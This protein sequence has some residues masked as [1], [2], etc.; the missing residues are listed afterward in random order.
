MS[1]CESNDDSK[2]LMNK[3]FIVE[4]I[5]NLKFVNNSNNDCCFFENY[6][7]EIDC[8]SQFDCENFSNESWQKLSIIWEKVV[9][10][11]RKLN[12]LKDFFKQMIT[13]EIERLSRYD[14]CKKL[15]VQTRWVIDQRCAI[16]KILKN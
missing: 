9:K 2:I 3:Y 10:Y 13:I 12:E 8:W 16:T 15:F 4:M 11:Y 1:N 6:E 14:N 5:D 7:K